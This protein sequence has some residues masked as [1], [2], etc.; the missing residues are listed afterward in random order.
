VDNQGTL[1]VAAG[2][3]FTLNGPLAELSGGTLSGGIYDIAGTFQFTGAA[4]TTNAATIILDGPG[5]QIVDQ[6]NNNALANFTTNAASGSFT[7]QDGQ[8]F[9]TGPAMVFS[10]A[11]TLTIGIGSTFNVAGS[12]SNFSDTTLTGGTFV[13]GGTLQFTGANLVTNAATIVLDSASAQ[14]VD[15]ANNN[16][17]ANFA[18]NAAAGSLTL[19]NGGHLTVVAFSNAGYLVI[20]SGSTFTATGTFSQSS[21]ATLVLY[22]TLRLTAGGAIDGTVINAGTLLFGAGAMFIVS[23]TYTVTGTLE[24]P[25]GATVDLTGT[26]TNFSGTTLTGGTYVIAGTLMFAGANI[27]T[28]AATIILDGQ[29]AQI[30]DGSNND[31][32]ANFT[33]NGGSFTIQNGRNFATAIS[34]TFDNAGVLAIGA[35]SRFSVMGGFA[36]FANQTLT[37]G[38]YDIAGTLQFANADIRTN[39]ATIVLD[40]PASQIVDLLGNDALANFTTNADTGSFTIQDGRNFATAVSVT[41]SNTGILVIAAGTTFSVT[42]GFAN[43]DGATLTGGSYRISGTFQF[44]GANIQTNAA[45]IV[46]NGPAAQI[47]DLANNDALTNFTTNAA[48]GSFT[49]GWCPRN[50][51]ELR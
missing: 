9:A 33:T 4:I 51:A 5:A 1:S 38:S 14:I 23:G 20:D 45:T 2:S 31:A 48:A 34:V 21:T 11:G 22:G 6:A 36:N 29:A 50:V 13:I 43:F 16:A 39:A 10:N 42:G 30:V 41:F 18:G 19:Q 44:V 26:F 17:L 24:V 8:S 46:L 49:I 25:A 28:N 15:Q 3:T 27:Q 7:V 35:G 32:L 37:G 12:L 47:L 40:G